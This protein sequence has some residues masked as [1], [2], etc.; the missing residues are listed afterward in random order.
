MDTLSSLQLSLTQ[1]LI[2]NVSQ[3]P[4]TINSAQIQAQLLSL[5]HSISVAC[6]LSQLNPA[7]GINTFCT[8]KN[9][10]VPHILHMHI[11]KQDIYIPPCRSALRT[12]LFRR[13]SPSP[14]TPVSRSPSIGHLHLHL[15]LPLLSLL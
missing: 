7:N 12:A 14:V 15:P 3:L 6:S 13:V 11:V 8:P 9:T 1:S 5:T 2:H 10:S 4:L